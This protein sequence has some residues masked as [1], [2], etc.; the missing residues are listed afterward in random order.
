VTVE[1]RKLVEIG[2]EPR[3]LSLQHLA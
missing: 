2:G 1:F 3:E